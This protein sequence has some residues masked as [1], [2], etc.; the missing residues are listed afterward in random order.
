MV[1]A[2][3]SAGADEAAD[4][5]QAAFAQ[6]ME[7]LAA[8]CDELKLP[9]QAAYTRGWALPLND[10]RLVYF[11]SRQAAT[12]PKPG[13]AQ[14]QQF[15]WEKFDG[16]RR[17]YAEQ[18]LQRARIL[19]DA[20]PVESY[21]LTW[22]ALR[23]QPDHALAR[24]LLHV[25]A[26]WDDP[27]AVKRLTGSP[28]V[29]GVALDARRTLRIES[30]H[31]VIFTAQRGPGVELAQA[32]E[33][34]HAAWRQVYVDTW[35]DQ[36]AWRASWSQSPPGESRDPRRHQVVLFPDRAEYLQALISLQSNVEASAGVY[37]EQPATSYFYAQDE[38]DRQTWLHEA[39]H[40]L[41]AELLGKA[42][43]AIAV[44]QNV[45]AVEGSALYME[46]L[47]AKGD[48]AR[49]G[50]PLTDRLQF[51]RLRALT[52]GFYEPLAEVAL[53][54]RRDWQSAELSRMRRLYT[55]SCG[56]T[57]FIMQD[58]SL[59]AAFGQLLRRIYR[60]DDQPDDFSS[61]A[62]TPPAEFDR[63]YLAFLV[64]VTDD[65]L[66]G[67]SGEENLCLT[68]CRISDQGL[69]SLERGKHL[70]WLD[71]SHT[72]VTSQGVQLLTEGQ[73]LRHLNLDSSQVDATAL[74]VIR[75]FRELE[76]LDLSRC[77]I[78]DEDLKQLASL[79]KLKV[80]WL[81]GCPITDE[82][83]TALR[84]LKQLESLHLE[85]T[86]TTEAGRERLAAAL[87]KL[88]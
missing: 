55:Q 79:K 67:Y 1:G 12:G 83:L 11:A 66:R 57:L 30:P 44:R 39:T 25:T 81:S 65:D 77:G 41:F 13:A 37:L 4:A 5:L 23:E 76:H 54:G 71:V 85:D 42:G 43:D 72:Q 24:R 48:H 32:L 21:R 17:R 73:G 33:Q 74:E 18:L 15:W 7:T 28:R 60:Q 80:L 68:R 47:K 87:P 50:G 64:S 59:R 31:F 19:A 61:L 10:P 9:D 36:Q 51:A 88:Q 14:L 34:L 56:W 22:A 75:T 3:S 63:R 2:G 86:Q 16:E 49:L 52:E 53:Q 26:C 58:A 35:L 8:K 27:V 29:A 6:T 69:R 70:R 45:W 40:Q 82:G 20:Q 38:Q 62:Q 84:G 46:S 78:H